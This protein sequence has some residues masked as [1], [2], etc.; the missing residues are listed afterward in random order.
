MKSM[1]SALFLACLASVAHGQYLTCD[2]ALIKNPRG[3]ELRELNPGLDELLGQIRS[4]AFPRRSGDEEP[5]PDYELALQML[6]HLRTDGL[7][8][9]EKSE[10]YDHFA[11][12][13]LALGD[14]ER[15]VSYA[16]MV[17]AEPTS[18]PDAL[19]NSL[20]TMAR[21]L[22]YTGDYCGSIEHW[23]AYSCSQG[24]LSAEEFVDL[25]QVLAGL[26]AEENDLNVP[27]RV[28][29]CRAM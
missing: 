27:V 29:Q 17:V 7:Q 11:S 22:A 12:L 16:K 1:V 14:T 3:N 15:A 18:N 26:G 6:Q 9:F 5:Q 2:E 21:H 24:G 25:R 28:A 13:Y 10:I 23:F 20:R 19:T 8:P 4:A